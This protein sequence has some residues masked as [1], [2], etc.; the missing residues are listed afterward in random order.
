[1]YIYIDGCI[2]YSWESVLSPHM[3]PISPSQQ[4]NQRRHWCHMNYQI[5][6]STN[7][8]WFIWVQQLSIFGY[9]RPLLKF[10][11]NR[12]IW[13]YYHFNCYP[14]IEDTLQNMKFH[15]KG[16]FMPVPVYIIII[17]D[18]FREVELWTL[19]DKLWE[20]ASKW[21]KNKDACTNP[22]LALFRKGS[23][24]AHRLII[25]LPQWVMV[26]MT[27]SYSNTESLNRLL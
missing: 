12:L 3:R 21:R 27:R 18:L 9:D 11:G 22:F 15:F 8:S 16:F 17:Q 19:Q 25:I 10:W 2:Q 4:N 6:L 7:Y 5:V 20:S 23:S 26:P 14:L 24:P 1:M 13:G